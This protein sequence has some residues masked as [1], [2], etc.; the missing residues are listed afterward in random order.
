MLMCYPIII[1]Q[2]GG[3]VNDDVLSQNLCNIKQWYL[4]TKKGRFY[5]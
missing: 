3:F 2:I 4:A 1:A 5:T